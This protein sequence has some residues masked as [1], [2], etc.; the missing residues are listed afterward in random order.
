MTKMMEE[1][2]FKVADN[3]YR[4]QCIMSLLENVQIIIKYFSIL[5]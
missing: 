2:Q 1:Y 3:V 5:R 4:K